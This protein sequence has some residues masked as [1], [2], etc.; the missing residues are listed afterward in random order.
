MAELG[1]SSL[2]QPCVI[3]GSCL[4]GLVKGLHCAVESVNSLENASFGIK[5][6][7]LV[8]VSNTSAYQ[9]TW[10]ATGSSCMMVPCWT[11]TSAG[12]E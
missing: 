3:P 10:L 12:D 9:G 7:I 6:C 11:K 2:K 4:L 5:V 8:G 1:N